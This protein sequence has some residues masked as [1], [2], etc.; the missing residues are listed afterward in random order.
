MP[1]ATLSTLLLTLQSST[2]MSEVFVS[3]VF[4]ANT[5]RPGP[6]SFDTFRI[7]A[8]RVNARR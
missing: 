3:N 1:T 4:A 5:R 6:L 2:F 8:D 7:P